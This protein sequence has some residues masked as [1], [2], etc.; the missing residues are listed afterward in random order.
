M[1]NEHFNRELEISAETKLKIGFIF[2]L[3]MMCFS[4]YALYFNITRECVEGR[5]RLCAKVCSEYINF[6]FEDVIIES[7][8]FP[9]LPLPWTSQTATV[10][11]MQSVQE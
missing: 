3:A 2:F 5:A 9:F 11:E 7:Y 1:K 8:P 6:L 10:T 4:S